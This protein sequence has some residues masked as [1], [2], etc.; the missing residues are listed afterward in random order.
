[1]RRKILG[2]SLVQC[3][4]RPFSYTHAPTHVMIVELFT[5][6][7]GWVRWGGGH[8]CNAP[9][10]AFGLLCYVAYSA[11]NCKI[12]PFNIAVDIMGSK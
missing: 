11:P 4:Y 1:M 5:S 7:R 9:V 6:T 2:V 8:T 3:A 12:R 10:Y